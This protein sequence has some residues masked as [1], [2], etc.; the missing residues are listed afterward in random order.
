VLGYAP[1]STVAVSEASTLANSALLAVTLDGVSI[2]IEG[3]V[4]RPKAPTVT[5]A[6]APGRWWAID[7]KAFYGTRAEAEAV[8]SKKT[9]A[10]QPAVKGK[11][12]APQPRIKPAPLS[13]VLEQMEALALPAFDISLYQGPA[14]VD[15]AKFLAELEVQTAQMQQLRAEIDDE[16]VLLL[17]L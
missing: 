10:P 14:A 6:G 3:S 9:E 17:S 12:Q 7:G 2:S 15:V 11:K 16:D 8:A 1:L 5:P 13:L 4:V